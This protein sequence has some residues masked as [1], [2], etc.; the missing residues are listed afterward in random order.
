MT[1]F[2]RR[3]CRNYPDRCDFTSAMHVMRAAMEGQHAVVNAIGSGTLFP[4][5][6]ESR[7]TAAAV[8]AAQGAHI[9]RYFAM[10]ARMVVADSAVFRDFV[11]PPKL[12]NAHATGY[13]GR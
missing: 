3:P 9:S 5:D 8:T 4:H 2:V 1:A 10:P 11:R 13:A 12:S 6:V 7:T